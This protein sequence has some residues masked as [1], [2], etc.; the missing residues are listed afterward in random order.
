[1]TK[2]IEVPHCDICGARE[3]SIFKELDKEQQS[4]LSA[5]KGCNFY[6][7]GQIVFFEG[8]RPF[9]LYC[10]SKGE[11]K[12]YKISENGK[13]QIFRFAKKGDILGYR[14]LIGGEAYQA[15]AETLSDSIICFIP[16]EI[17]LDLIEKDQPFSMKF[18]KFLCGELGTAENRMLNITQKPVKER[19]AEVLLILKEK[20]GMEDDDKT[21]NINLTREDLAN[22]VGTATETIVRLLGELREG[23]FIEIEGRKIK[24]INI[25][26]LIRV[27][28][29]F[30]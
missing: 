2:K 12:I 9:G 5:A 3:A 24:L 25:P 10:V 19:L 7:K 26:G 29:V 18:M 1:M 30:D 20:F 16:K 28:N 23:K 8:N 14:A 13:E 11:I 27:G 6:R 21:L 15:T 22:F 17:L 4:E